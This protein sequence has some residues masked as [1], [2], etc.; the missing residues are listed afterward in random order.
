LIAAHVLGIKEDSRLG[1]IQTLWNYI[2]VQG[3]Q[4]KSDRRMIHAD[5]KLRAVSGVPQQF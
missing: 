3:L 2:K 4:D 1:V 5:D